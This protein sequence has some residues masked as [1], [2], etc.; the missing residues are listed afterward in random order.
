VRARKPYA[1]VELRV[2]LAHDRVVRYE[3]T[4]TMNEEL[5]D[6][7]K[8]GERLARAM[9]KALA[10]AADHVAQRTAG[11]LAAPPAKSER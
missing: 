2:A 9:A 3:E 7:S 1:E 6:S 5:G 11:S 10:R 8:G 4:I